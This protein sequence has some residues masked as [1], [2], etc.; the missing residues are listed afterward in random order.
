[1]D[2]NDI[3]DVIGLDI[4]VGAS[5]IY[6]L[7]AAKH[8]NWKML[9]TEANEDNFKMAQKNVDSNNLNDK[10]KLALTT[11]SEHE[12][13]QLFEPIEG[14]QEK[15]SFTMCNPPFYG[16]DHDEESDPASDTPA[17]QDHEL[18]TK[19]GE[20]EFISKMISDSKCVADKIPIFTCMVGHKCSLK[21]L[22]KLCH[23]AEAKDK[24][25]RFSDTEFCQGKTMRWAL[26]WTFNSSTKLDTGPSLLKKK[27]TERKL[28]TPVTFTLTEMGPGCPIS[29]GV[30]FMGQLTSWLEAIDVIVKPGKVENERITFTVKSFQQNWKNQRRR[31]REQERAAVAEPSSKKLKSSENDESEQKAKGDLQLSAKFSATLKDSSAH[32]EIV[33]IDGEAGKDGLYQLIQFLKN[34]AKGL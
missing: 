33:F 10:I 29:D 5:G 1:M 8:L 4:G 16:E 14:M 26:V 24:D 28:H 19:G 3:K 12:Q 23:E 20:V 7:L 13:S 30:S 21:A 11:S 32:F 22:K 25:F 34:K 31:R 2:A 6:P 17:G 9:G 18:K 27:Q 15:I